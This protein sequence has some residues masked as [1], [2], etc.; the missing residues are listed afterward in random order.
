MAKCV[1]CGK[2]IVV[3]NIDK[4]RG[5]VG[6]TKAWVHKSRRANR[7]HRAIPEEALR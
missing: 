6:L 3:V 1:A 4:M 5:I 7:N 2:E